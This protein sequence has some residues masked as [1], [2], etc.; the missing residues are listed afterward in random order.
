MGWNE[1]KLQRILSFS[2]FQED[3]Y[4]CF[5]IM[6]L[7]VPYSHKRKGTKFFFFSLKRTL[8]KQLKLGM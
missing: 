6:Y 3:G 2:M 5:R 8:S 1:E 4:V 7:R